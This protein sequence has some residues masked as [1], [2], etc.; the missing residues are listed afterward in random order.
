MSD[1]A[2]TVCRGMTEDGTFRVV[3]T[4]T[5]DTVRGAIERQGVSGETARRFGDLLTGVVLLRL[6][7]APQLRV[8]G[9]L[10]GSGRTGTLVADSH[11]SGQTRGLVTSGDQGPLAIG[12]GGLLR[13]MRTMQDGRLHQGLV[14][15]SSGDIS[16]ALMTYMQTSEQVTT[17]ISVGTVIGEDGAVA[18]GGYLVQLLPGAE[19]GPLMIMSQR[20]QDDFG[21][22]DDRLKKPN[23]SPSALLDDLLY[24]MPFAKVGETDVRYECWCSHL[25]VLSA[26][27][28][29]PRTEVQSMI[30]AGEVLEISCD[31]CTKQYNI[32]PQELR[33]LLAAS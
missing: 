21:T 12:P 10:R 17:M 2:D 30:D 1:A 6:T 7:M 4:R 26:L 5:S 9:I 33:G 13:L 3:T 29:L 20:L 32:A 23:F 27:A 15:V 8:Q 31:Y 22:I 19:R 16:Q 14:E 11:P 28:T 25:S 24:G 18:S